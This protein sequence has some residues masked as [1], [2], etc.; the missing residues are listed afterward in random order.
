MDRV[1]LETAFTREKAYWKLWLVEVMDFAFQT[2]AVSKCDALY[3][4]FESIEM[5]LYAPIKLDRMCKECNISEGYLNRK[6]RELMGTSTMDYVQRRKLLI[7]KKKLCL[8]DVNLGDI[9]YELGYNES[10]YFSK[11]FKK[12][13]GVSPIQYRKSA[14]GQV[15]V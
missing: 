6:M 10:S 14:K 3:K 13:E 2:T 5:Y 1:Q 12:Y 15:Q 8:Q 7:A 9:A 4:V 11:V